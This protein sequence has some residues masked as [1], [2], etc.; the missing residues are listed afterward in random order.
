MFSTY[1]L[2]IHVLPII[3]EDLIKAFHNFFFFATRN[4]PKG[5]NISFLVLVPKVVG[6]NSLAKVLSS[7]LN[8]ILLQ[9]AFLSVRSIL[10]YSMIAL[11]LIHII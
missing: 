1:L 11:E 9:Q 3:K 5:I 4:V 7:R 8:A 10:D 2:S 6:S